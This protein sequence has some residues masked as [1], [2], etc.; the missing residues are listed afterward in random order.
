M[1]NS[2]SIGG[3]ILALRK[4]KGITQAELGAYLNISYQAVSKWERDESCPDFATM[5]KLAKYFNVQLSYFEEVAISETVAENTVAM[6]TEEVEM[7][8]CP[9]CGKPTEIGNPFCVNCDGYIG[10]REKD[11]EK[12]THTNAEKLLN[13]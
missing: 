8:V 2:E 5:S 10:N 13:I 12:I 4:A 7:L 3:K 11:C 9:F 6:E 1:G